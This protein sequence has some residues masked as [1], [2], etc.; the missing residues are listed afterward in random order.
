MRLDWPHLLEK[1]A[2]RA[3]GLAGELAEAVGALAREEGDGLRGAARARPRQGPR[4]QGLAGSRL[5]VEQDAPAWRQLAFCT[6]TY[7]MAAMLTQYSTTAVHR[8]LMCA[9]Q[10]EILQGCKHDRED[11]RPT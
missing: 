8:A 6:N 1:Q 9:T 5:A 3:L 7:I 10:R 2:Q 4:H 11:D